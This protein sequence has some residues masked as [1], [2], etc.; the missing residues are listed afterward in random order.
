MPWIFCVAL[1]KTSAMN[2]LWEHLE[3]LKMATIVVAG[4]RVGSDLIQSL[5]DGHP[6]VI[7]FEGVLFFDDFYRSAV[8]LWGT[9]AS[10]SK[11]E[12]L[13]GVSPRDFFSEFAWKH[14]HAFHS[15]YDTLENKGHLGPSRDQS[16]DVDMEA[17]VLHAEKLMEGRELSRR[18]AFL[19]VH[20]AFSLAR[21][22]ELRE[23]K[24][25]LHHIHDI[26]KLDPLIGDFPGLKV[27]AAVRDPRAG[28][29]STMEHTLHYAGD[30]VNPMMHA[31]VVGRILREAGSLVGKEGIEVRVNLLEK[32]HRQPE[33]VLREMCGWLGV[34]FHPSLLQ[35]TWGGKLWWGDA[36]ST[37]IRSTFNPEMGEMS[38][39]RWMRELSFQDRLLLEVLTRKKLDQYGYFR[40]YRRR[41]WSFVALLLIFF[42]MRYERILFGK[43]LRPVLF[44]RWIQ[45]VS[46]RCRWMVSKWMALTL[47]RE[48]KCETF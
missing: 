33:K 9:G 14:L 28:Y 6:E 11:S 4:G 30:R 18:N 45:G 42:P 21:G 25:L 10:F 2:D 26:E 1:V 20:A 31:Y 36:L 13:P 48:K 23:K 17:F 34:S 15:R 43:S 38:R 47:G 41:F 32:L 29:L 35:S 27:I 19:A 22:E 3:R 39:T 12:R 37:G 46:R 24:L 16:N 40:K 44:L 8:S 7:T 5:F